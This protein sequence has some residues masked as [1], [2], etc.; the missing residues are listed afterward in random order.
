[1]KKI[2]ALELRLGDCIHYEDAQDN[3][4]I[5]TAIS[6]IGP[7][8]CVSLHV[9]IGNMNTRCIA[10]DMDHQFEYKGNVITD[11]NKE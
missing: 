1:M 7:E 10:V 5:I 3:N 6:M 2:K 9:A 11:S 8:D 4:G